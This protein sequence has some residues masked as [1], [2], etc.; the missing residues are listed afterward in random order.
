MKKAFTLNLIFG[1]LAAAMVLVFSTC[2]K[3]TSGGSAGI[4]GK[5]ENKAFA[6]TIYENRQVIQHYEFKSNDSVE[7]YDYKID[8]ITKKI[9]GYGFRATGKYKIDKSVLTM[10]NIANF[11]NST[12]TFV[13]VAQLVQESSSGTES[14]TFT[15]NG[16]KNQLSLYFACPINADCVPGPAIYN[17]IE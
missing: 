6:N 3:D 4:I 10:Y 7:F 1:L 9:L 12:G 14:C 2:K 17:R 8:T 15:L 11:S 13:P 16:Q 5:W